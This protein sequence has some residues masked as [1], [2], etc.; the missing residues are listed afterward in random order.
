MKRYILIILLALS[1]CLLCACVQPNDEDAADDGVLT[2]DAIPNELITVG[3]VV[4]TDN[5]NLRQAP[6]QEARIIDNVMA[7]TMLRVA[8]EEPEDGW[9]RVIVRGDVAYVYAD[10]LYVSQWESG[11]EFTRGTVT[12]D[13]D[14]VE[15]RSAASATADVIATAG[16]YQQFVV[17]EENVDDKWYRVDYKGADAYLPLGALALENVCIDDVLW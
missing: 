1:L 11:T 16:R 4:D 2:A 17:L 15:L 9:Y 14:E 10:F 5:V 3:V 8:K 6:S 12:K 13:V 7:G